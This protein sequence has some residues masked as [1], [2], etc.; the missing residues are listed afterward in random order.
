MQI[1]EV[2]IADIPHTMQLSEEDA[3]RYNATEH[4][5]PAARKPKTKP[6]AT[7]DDAD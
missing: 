7:G 1:Y 5:A 2:K 4:K 6:V 3:K